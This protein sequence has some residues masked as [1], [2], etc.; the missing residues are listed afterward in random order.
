MCGRYSLNPADSDAWI[1]ERIDLLNRHA[2]PQAALKTQ[3]DVYP[4]DFVPVVANNRR[5]ESSVFAMQWGYSVGSRRIINARSEEAA[6]KPLFMDGM[7]RRRC[8][9]PADSYY[10]WEK[11]DGMRIKYAIR[12]AQEKEFFLAGLYRLEFDRPVFTILT[13][14]AAG[15]I[16]FIHERMPVLLPRQL[17]KDWLDPSV[18]AQSLLSQA[19][20]DVCWE[21]CNNPG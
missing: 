19:I 17:M 14:Q 18:P 12:P 10:E 21:A 16:A 6:E 8:L 2:L 4:S 11:R 15:C 7:R 13:R 20:T 5:M 3:G 1:A 9:I